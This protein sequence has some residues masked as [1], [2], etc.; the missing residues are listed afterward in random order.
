MHKMDRLGKIAY[1]NAG[2]NANIEQGNPNMH[3]NIST[4][5]FALFFFFR[6]RQINI[7]NMEK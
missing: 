4:D 6:Q 5:T 7:R 3:T 1:K 2:K